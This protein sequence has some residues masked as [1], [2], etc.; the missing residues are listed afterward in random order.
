MKLM[1][2]SI[3]IL[4]LLC[5][6]SSLLGCGTDITYQPTDP[7]SISTTE[8]SVPETAFS[9][10]SEVTTEPQTEPTDPVTAPTTQP[11]TEPVTQPATEPATEPT[12]APTQ[13][14]HHFSPATCTDPKICSTCGET[15]GKAAGHIWK[16]ATCTTPKT[17]RSCGDT[18]GSKADHDY[19][20][21]VCQ[22]CG[23]DQPNYSTGEMVWIPKSGKRYHRN[24]SCSN[25]KGPSQVTKSQAISWGYTPCK[26]CY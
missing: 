26:K 13:H 14:S 2:R 17:C 12:P 11:I 4:L 1:K 18:K 5:I 23:K 3:S 7:T 20:G 15:E 9:H 6:L 25:M 8:G 21:G 22:S 24:S 19:S 16:D 10:P